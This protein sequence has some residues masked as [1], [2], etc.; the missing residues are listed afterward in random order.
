M[1]R[2]SI[3]KTAEWARKPLKLDLS[4]NGSVKRAEVKEKE[5]NKVPLRIDNNTVIMVE[6][7]QCTTRY[8][9]QFKQKINNF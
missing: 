2:K 7:E 8:A 6:K 5:S 3:G 9:E 4:K 1:P